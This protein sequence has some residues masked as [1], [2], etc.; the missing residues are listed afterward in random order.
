MGLASSAQMNPGK[1]TIYRKIQGWDMNLSEMDVDC[2]G[3]VNS[4]HFLSIDNR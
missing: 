1:P 3:P 4:S 2:I